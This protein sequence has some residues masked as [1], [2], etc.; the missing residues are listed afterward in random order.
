M[1]GSSRAVVADSVQQ[2]LRSVS[3]DGVGKD[4]AP[5]D[6]VAIRA[7]VSI[8]GGYVGRYLT[9][10]DFRGTMGDKC[11]SCLARGEIDRDD[12]IFEEL[13]LGMESIDE[14][15]Q[16]KLSRA[17][18]RMKTLRSS[19]RLLSTLA[20]L[21]SE[22]SRNQLTCG[23]PNSR[24]SACAQL[25]LSIVYKIERNDRVC[26]RHLLQVFCDSPFLART[27][28]LPDLWEHFFL[29]HLLHLMVWY[30][31]ELEVLSSHAE[32]KEEKMKALSKVYNDQL[33]MGTA[34]FAMY[35]K[36]WLKIGVD[37][38]SVPKVTLPSRSSYG[39][40]RRR[41]L[42]SLT[43]QSSVNKSL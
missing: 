32:D 25:Y 13:R 43:S 5:I 11:Q 35:Y 14:L 16:E 26:A 18:A 9:D 23:V 8:L 10:E 4:E 24:I 30:H 37:A 29:P 36:D 7:V 41:S 21:N 42:D 6:E 15:V 28:L 38:P 1:S 22:N 20:S 19:I 34:K 31:Q 27:Y 17:D 39:S 12:H 2:C 40:W 3:R 33:D